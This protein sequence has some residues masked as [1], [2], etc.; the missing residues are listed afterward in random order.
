MNLF[1][2]RISELTKDDERILREYFSGYDYRG[3]SYTFL[4]T[5]IWRDDYEICW[6]IIEGYLCM[7]FCMTGEDA[8]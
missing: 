8:L 6:D 1:G 4:A 3:A 5:Y 7:V 2:H